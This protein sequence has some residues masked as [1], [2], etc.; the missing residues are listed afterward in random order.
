MCVNELYVIVRLM[1]LEG[2]S[3]YI[4][5]RIPYRGT[6]TSP[7]RESAAVPVPRLFYALHSEVQPGPT[8]K[9]THW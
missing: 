7:V 8:R 6:Q 9:V 2:A 3:C 4:E 5:T 1:M